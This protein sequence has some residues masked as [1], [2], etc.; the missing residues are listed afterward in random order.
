MPNINLKIWL[1]NCIG[2]RREMNK[3][4]TNKNESLSSINEG[5]ACLYL[6][7]ICIEKYFFCSCPKV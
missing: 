2:V 7:V 6:G 3:E 5:R 4:S 1:K